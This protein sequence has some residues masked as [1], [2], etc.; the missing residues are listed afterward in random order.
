MM[1]ITPRGAS[2]PLAWHNGPLRI[3][4][5]IE[6]IASR[7]IK[8]PALDFKEGV[9]SIA[10]DRK[11]RVKPIDP[12]TFNGFR[13]M[14]IERVTIHCKLSNGS[15]EFKIPAVL[16]ITRNGAQPSVYGKK[17]FEIIINEITFYS[18]PFTLICQPIAQAASKTTKKTAVNVL[19]AIKN[20]KQT[21]KRK[22]GQGMSKEAY[23]PNPH[24]KVANPGIVKFHKRDET[25]LYS[26]K[27]CE[28][29]WV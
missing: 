15:I 2:Y 7:E 20:N 21:L 22:P 11:Y 19:C 23:R 14:Q 26:E 9:L 29:K 5:T 27:G 28:I 25:K 17:R 12:Q 8:Y 16:D 1:A 24:L 4:T 10:K 3:Q 18:D 13:G 6:Q